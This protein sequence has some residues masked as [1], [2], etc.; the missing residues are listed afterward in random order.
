MIGIGEKHFPVGDVLPG[1]VSS[2]VERDSLKV[3]CRAQRPARQGED[4]QKLV[5]AGEFVELART[6]HV[7]EWQGDVMASRQGQQ[8]RWLDGALQV[9]VQFS[10]GK[11]PDKIGQ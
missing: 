11:P 2:Q 7:R 10:F 6:R 4:F 9:A 8:G 3:C 5:Q 1:R